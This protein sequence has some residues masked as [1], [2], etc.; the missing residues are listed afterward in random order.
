MGSEE[1]EQVLWSS[2]ALEFLSRA[3]LGNI[4]PALLAETNNGIENLYF[5]LGFRPF[6]KKF[7]PK[8]ITVSEVFRRLSKILP[9]FNKEHEDF[10]LLHTE[11]RNTELHTGECAFDSIKNSTWQPKFYQT[12]QTLLTSMNISLEE[13]VGKDEAEAA[14]KL[15]NSTLDENAKS[16]KGEVDAHKKVWEGKL[17]TERKTLKEQ[18]ELWATRQNGHRVDCPS[19]S[20]TARCW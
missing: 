2:F 16:V 14:K 11:K 17:E 3:A 6:G 10:G 15:I 1:W 13:F 5:S 4:S 9:E 12:C 20:S 7:L 19:C 18:S 8:S